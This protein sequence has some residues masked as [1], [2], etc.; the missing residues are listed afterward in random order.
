M[1]FQEFSGSTTRLEYLFENSARQNPDAPCVDY[2]GY[3][4]SY[5]ELDRRAELLALSLKGRG[6][7]PGDYVGVCLP[8]GL[9][10]Y[11]ALLGILKAGAA[12]VPLDPGLPIERIRFIA[13][14]AGLRL[15]LDEGENLIYS[16][17]QE[18][19]S[20]GLN[21]FNW[22]EQVTS[23]EPRFRDPN[24]VCYVCY[25]SGTTGRPKGV[26]VRH[27]S[28]VNFVRVATDCYGFCSSD[29]VYQGMSA[30]FDFS[31]EEIWTTLC[32][33]ATL[34]PRP[35]TVDRLG[36]G[37]NDFLIGEKVTVLTCVPTLLATLNETIP[38]LRL[39]NVGGEACP[40]SLVD[41]W[42]RPELKILNTYGPTEA[43]VTA[44][45][46][47]LV[48]GRPVSIGRP[49]PTY[50]IYI[51]DHDLLEVD[52]GDIGE[53]CIAGPG[54][55]EGYLNRADLTE[56]RFVQF[57]PSGGD[58]TI[59]LYRTGDLGR[60]FH[61]GEIEYLGRMDD[62]IKIN[63]FRVELSEIEEVLRGFRGVA[64]AVVALMSHG[65]ENL[66]VG[67]LVLDTHEGEC[68][69]SLEDIKKGL[70]SEL[71]SYMLPAFLELLDVLPTMVSGKIDR[72]A[73]PPPT[74]PAMA[75]EDGHQSL[76]PLQQQIHEIWCEVFDRKSIP[77]DANFF[78]D[79]GGQSLRVAQVI[80][81]LRHISPY[82]MISM[83]DLY[84]Y[85]SLRDFCAHLA[86]LS[87][88]DGAKVLHSSDA[89]ANK[90]VSSHRYFGMGLMQLLFLTFY[91]GA[92]FAP[93][94]LLL[95]VIDWDKPFWEGW[96]AQRADMETFFSTAI[97]FGAA[98][99]H[100]A[101][102]LLLPMVM[103]AQSFILPVLTKWLI[104]GRLKPGRYP[105]WGGTYFRWW[106]ARRMMLVAPVYLL[107]G[108]P[109]LNRY[110]SLLGGRI[111]SAAFL[112]T[113]MVET[114]EL[115]QI[116]AGAMIGYQAALQP[117]QIK[118]GWLHLGKIQIGANASVGAKSLL[119]HDTKMGQGAILGGLSL[120][121][122]GAV[123]P[124]GHYWS[125]SPAVERADCEEF[126]RSIRA[127]PIRWNLAYQMLHWMG[128]LS[129]FSLPYSCSISTLYLIS[130]L[131]N[132]WGYGAIPFIVV[133]G[134][135]CFTLQMC[136]LISFLKGLLPRLSPGFYP[137]AGRFGLSKWVSD[138]L[139]EMSLFFLNPL[140]STLYTPLWLRFMGAK[141][142]ARAEV[143]TVSDIDPDLLTLGEECFVA[144][145]AAVGPAAFYH[146]YFKIAET[147]VGRRAFVG[148][149]ALIPANTRM[150]DESLLGVSSMPPAHVISHGTSWLG[151]PAL[152]LPRREIMEMDDGVTYTPS[153]LQVALRL[154]IEF[155]RVTLPPGLMIFATSL[156]LEFYESDY[157]AD[158]GFE[159]VFAYEGLLVIEVTALLLL[160][161]FAK[162]L[163]M[164]RYRT[165]TEP[166]WSFFVR[167]SELVTALYENI[168]VPLVLD[169]LQGTP[170]I[171][172]MLRLFGVKIG[173]RVF[174]DTTFLTEFDLVDIGDDCSIGYETSLQTHLF[175]DRV[176]KMSTI[177]IETQ[178]GVGSHSVVLYDATVESSA[179][180]ADLSL[181]M[182]GESIPKG[183]RWTG[184]PARATS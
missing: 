39:L 56:E 82:Q 7:E 144:D 127:R 142:G 145:M 143:S 11:V 31:V 162:W 47:E 148:N 99:A 54:L 168:P 129:L 14:D 118:G 45:W 172:N 131:M 152:F 9:H 59:R 135:F 90:K 5:R 88:S 174:L 60:L 125:G 8:P 121:N 25:T 58:R 111:D 18:L 46:T 80:S 44:T 147:H 26:V 149:A 116:E 176:M 117:Y 173:R 73:L 180:V 101:W 17:I 153:K 114:P 96:S 38:S 126:D 122:C 170:W 160:V 92:F 15:I 181:V 69:P 130:D 128:V 123:I 63:G 72:K 3:L 132:A 74:W 77:L 136:F 167:R 65:G 23:P 177:T 49:L 161:V 134:G 57:K 139:V 137:V 164:G 159:A 95:H 83:G 28:I 50:E 42:A 113:A 32:A 27:S 106:V 68:P 6:V 36:P 146:G 119:L 104:V 13:D 62:Q 151:S 175:E 34:V 43:T 108:T 4:I 182:K 70:A 98:Q 183:T 150:D 156:V 115:V 40:S 87:S 102:L 66:L 16:K 107:A 85:P 79:L 103:L 89:I 61:D 48:P 93:M 55:A 53:I 86:K 112:A 81:V 75:H 184:L 91:L 51:V 163:V 141:V 169:W 109:L 94:G 41:R 20:L 1:T 19:P 166:N 29:R 76:D 37:L 97:P 178:A 165:R 22:S 30:A 67:Y 24:A 84:E 171:C 2:L 33:G 133:L 52:S 158:F 10:L 78:T 21:D 138:K 179:E 154:L 12:Y 157:F 140:Y 71:P 100:Q 105:L 155:F 110:L 124:D 64:D 120:L 35:S